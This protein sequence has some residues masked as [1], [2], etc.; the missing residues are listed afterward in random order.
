MPSVISPA[1]M[2]PA[3]R[4]STGQNTS[5]DSDIHGNGEKTP[6]KQNYQSLNSPLLFD[7]L[8]KIPTDKKHTILDISN[9][10]SD[11]IDFFNDYT[12]K[13]F[14]TN[15]ITEIHKLSPDSIN[16]QHK[17]HRA[18]VKSMGFYKKDKAELDIILLWGL[19]NY[20]PPDQ[21]KQLIEYLLPQCS[22]RTYLHAYIFNSEKMTDSPSNYRIKNNNKIGV[23]P[24]NTEKEITCPMY[25]LSDLQQHLSPF[26]LEH[27]VMLSSGIQEYLF[28]LD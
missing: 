6:H 18:L 2:T 23:Y 19:A 22:E 27:S 25:H 5:A 13:L 1:W 11:S 14:I 28:Q 12:C 26:K 3:H 24:Q 20:L 9:A 4:L 16:T 10:N 7:L 21:L 17:W 8:N 15:S